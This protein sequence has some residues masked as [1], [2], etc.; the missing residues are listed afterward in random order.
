MYVSL[1]NCMRHNTSFYMFNKDV[2]QVK[3]DQVQRLGYLFDK[4][5][6]TFRRF[7]LKASAIWDASKA[8]FK[9]TVTLCLGKQYIAYW[10]GF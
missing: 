9:T 3:Q 7:S 10:N 6:I 5:D 4:D 2:T 1:H 8:S